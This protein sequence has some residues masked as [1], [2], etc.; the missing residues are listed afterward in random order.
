MISPAYDPGD[1]VSCAPANPSAAV[2][3]RLPILAV[4]LL[5]GPVRRRQS[6]K[7]A[8]VVSFYN[9][10]YGKA[11]KKRNENGNAKR[12]KHANNVAKKRRCVCP[13]KCGR[14]QD[15]RLHYSVGSC[16]PCDRR[17][18]SRHSRRVIIY[19]YDDLW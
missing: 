13:L 11:Q 17:K 3:T 16:D 1:R 18:T 5:H 9:S 4:F 2:V 15:A 19:G 6:A 8:G 12:A 10:R 7:I 14:T